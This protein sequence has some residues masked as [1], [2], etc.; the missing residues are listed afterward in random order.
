MLSIDFIRKNTEKVKRAAELKNRKVDIDELLR[1]DEEY[2]KLLAETETLRAE[3]NKAAK[4][5]KSEEAIK[6]G[7]EIKE[8]LKIQEDAAAQLK[9]QVDDLLLKVPN[10]PYEETPIGAD[11]NDNK[12]IKRVGEP[13]K[14]D[15]EPLSHMDL[16]AKH[17]LAD[18]ERGAKTSGY[19]GYFL[20][21]ELAQL[22]LAVLMYA[23][24]KISKKGYIPFIAPTLVKEFTLFGS[25]QL[26]WGRDEVY[27]L[28]KDDMYLSGTAEIPMTSYYSDEILPE[29]D[30]PKKFVAFSPCF[31][32]EIGNYGKDTKGLYRVHEFWKVEQVVVGPADESASR[33]IHEELLKNSEEIMTDLELPYRILLMCTG[34]MG[35]PQAKKYDLELWMPYRKGWGEIGSDSIMTDFQAR[36]VKLRYR[37][38]SGE[39]KFAYT[40][41]NT[42]VPSP[43]ILIAILENYQQKDGTILVPKVLQPFVGF[44]KIGK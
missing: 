3:R 40:Y 34:D 22:H 18:F 17:D 36:R 14:F 29:K 41:N 15:F 38:A 27:H 26:P 2:K 25:A 32:R 33:T 4:L 20:K 19:R 42:A 30:L 9:Q 21:R 28:E 44:D 8:A 12:E 16:V 13:R 6:R 31:R 1:L 23:F 39:V 11:E 24:M 7:K 35:E 37:T 43:R 10:I 5:G